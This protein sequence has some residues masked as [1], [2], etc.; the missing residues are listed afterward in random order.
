MQSI[1]NLISK[2][3]N[4]EGDSTKQVIDLIVFAGYFS[5]C[6]Y[7]GGV[8]YNSSYN[9]Y[10]SLQKPIDI[11]DSYIAVK[12]VT[13]VLATGWLWLA[14][15][16]Y[17]LLFI[18]LYY[19]CR[20]AWKPWIGYFIMSILLYSTFLMCGVIGEKKGERDAIMDGFKDTTGLPVVKLYSTDD[21]GTSYSDGNYHLLFSDDDRFYIFEPAGVEGSVIQI[22][23]VNRKDIGYYEITV[24]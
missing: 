5:F 1:Q 15:S 11:K 6:L 2:F 19:S 3:K 4:A 12:F 9:E 21:S 13:H 22:T 14:S 23:V 24:K 18:F 17:I 20:Y 8:A 10:F 16:V 7:A